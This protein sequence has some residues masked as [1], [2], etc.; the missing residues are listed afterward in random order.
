MVKC[1]WCE[2]PL[3][4]HLGD[5]SNIDRIPVKNLEQ[6][7]APLSWYDVYYCKECSSVIFVDKYDETN[8]RG[9]TCFGNDY[10]DS[11]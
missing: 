4:I 5:D 1:K 2:E 10:L 8:Q 7:A 11:L 3:F 9:V 6:Y